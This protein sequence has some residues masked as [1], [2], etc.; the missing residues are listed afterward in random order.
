MSASKRRSESNPQES[1]HLGPGFHT[2]SGS[3]YSY[4]SESKSRSR[5]RSPARPES[6]ESSHT[7]RSYSE[8][9][10]REDSKADDR[11]SIDQSRTPRSAIV[12][13]NRNKRKPTGGDCTRSMRDRKGQ[14]TSQSAGTIIRKAGGE[15]RQV[16]MPDQL[17]SSVKGLGRKAK[18]SVPNWQAITNDLDKTTISSF[19]MKVGQVNRLFAGKVVLAQEGLRLQYYDDELRDLVTDTTPGVVDGRYW[20]KLREKMNLRQGIAAQQILQWIHEPS[21]AGAES[22]D[23]DEEPDLGRAARGMHTRQDEGPTRL[24]R[25]K[26]ADQVSRRSSGSKAEETRS[27]KRT[28]DSPSDDSPKETRSR[29]RTRDSPSDDSPKGAKK[30]RAQL[31]AMKER[32]HS[33]WKR[34]N[35]SLAEAQSSKRA[36]VEEE[37]VE[38]LPP[39]RPHDIPIKIFPKGVEQQKER[40]IK[41]K[42]LDPS[43]AEKFREAPHDVAVRIM[44]K[45]TNRAR[46]INALVVSLLK[47]YNRVHDHRRQREAAEGDEGESGGDP[48]PPPT[49]EEGA[50]ADEDPPEEEDPWGAGFLAFRFNQKARDLS[51]VD[52]YMLIIMNYKKQKGFPKGARREI[53]KGRKYKTRWETPIAA[54]L[55]EYWEETNE[56]TGALIRSK[57]GLIIKIPKGG[58]QKAVTRVKAGNKDTYIECDGVRYFCAIYASANG[59]LTGA[60]ESRLSW[61]VHDKD[62]IKASWVPLSQVVD[63]ND[64]VILRKD[65]REVALA[66]WEA[67]CSDPEVINMAWHKAYPSSGG[68][69]SRGWQ[70]DDTR[71]PSAEGASGSRQ[72]RATTLANQILPR[73]FEREKDALQDSDKTTT[74]PGYE[75][76]VG[77][78]QYPR[79]GEDNEAIVRTI[80]VAMAQMPED[81]KD[82]KWEK[83]K[84]INISEEEDPWASPKW[85][86]LCQKFS[87]GM[88]CDQDP[89]SWTSKGGE[90]K[91][92][93][94]SLLVP[95][96]PSWVMDL[97]EDDRWK[98]SVTVM[99]TVCGR[100]HS[101]KEHL[102]S[103]DAI[104]R[105]Q[106]W[107]EGQTPFIWYLGDT[108]STGSQSRWAGIADPKE[109]NSS[110]GPDHAEAWS[111]QR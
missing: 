61:T 17:N 99:F 18:R 9:P 13:I 59:D 35:V 41:D 90:V 36:K 87:D 39:S 108:P 24:A 93:G 31:P 88:R 57:E 42:K 16:N 69:P 11:D 100:W 84:W 103:Q 62:V 43:A 50:V 79:D 14:G 15:R 20:D 51:A 102:G 22:S 3:D 63:G 110:V 86:G 111:I 4:S 97:P 49:E 94:C 107:V 34:G 95:I 19:L 71:L 73:T 32:L 92:H 66:G 1:I 77:A 48:P 96:M 81:T 54:A 109:R 70:E 58:G 44:E 76:P 65:W 52:P 26:Q 40:F 98:D 56:H 89:C 8:E 12:E 2:R 28:R 53:P 72:D 82:V 6:V 75:V 27:R 21:L 91:Y 25:T 85:C 46:N 45:K 67:I 38:D 60:P 30:A 10:R 5:S 101:N 64:P 7:D 55:R 105:R 33:K 78:E 104:A 68:H 83:A 29:K 80:R 47:K 23:E 74:A 37:K 106:N